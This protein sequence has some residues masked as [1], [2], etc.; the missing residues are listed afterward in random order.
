VALEPW[1]P[2]SLLASAL[3]HVG[4]L[5]EVL[6]ITIIEGPANKPHVSTNFTNLETVRFPSDTLYIKIT[7]TKKL[8]PD[9]ISGMLVTIA[10]IE[11]F[12]F[13]GS[14]LKNQLLMKYMKP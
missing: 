6:E 4:V 3:G 2:C 13:L 1:R 10:N 11:I 5:T 9:Y 12:S 8:R 7:L 14:L